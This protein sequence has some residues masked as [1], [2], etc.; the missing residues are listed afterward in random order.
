MSFTCSLE[1]EASTF[2]PIDSTCSS[3]RRFRG[4]AL[5]SCGQCSRFCAVNVML[6]AADSAYLA[7]KA[8]VRPVGC[9]LE[10]HIFQQ[11]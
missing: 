7:D 4:I 8:E 11:M 2:A 9:A 3:K 1:A 5:M 10:S 6:A